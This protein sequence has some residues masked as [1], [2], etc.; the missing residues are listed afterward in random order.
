[1]AMMLMLIK[2]TLIRIIRKDDNDNLENS[3]N[4]GKDKDNTIF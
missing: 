2:T 4:N 1:M 3:S